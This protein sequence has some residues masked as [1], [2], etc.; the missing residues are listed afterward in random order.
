[1]T[2]FNRRQFLQAGG[3]VLGAAALYACARNPKQTPAPTPDYE[4][5]TA[6]ELLDKPLT[7]LI[8]VFGPDLKESFGRIIAAPDV[9]PNI[10]KLSPETNR[11][12]INPF[13]ERLVFDDG[14]PTSK[15]PRTVVYLEPWVTSYFYSTEVGN[16]SVG[17]TG[18]I[19]K[20]GVNVITTGEPILSGT[21]KD[22]VAMFFAADAL[23][24]VLG[25]SLLR[26]LPQSDQLGEDPSMVFAGFSLAVKNVRPNVDYVSGFLNRSVCNLLAE[27]VRN[28]GD[29]KYE[30]D[31]TRLVPGDAFINKIIQERGISIGDLYGLHKV[32]DIVGFTSRLSG[33]PE[34]ELRQNGLFVISMMADLDRLISLIEEGSNTADESFEEYS[35]KYF[36]KLPET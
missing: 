13:K 35:R 34:E 14:Q 2:E 33:Q 31:E 20:E 12:D 22:A 15:P 30:L 26:Q 1:M 6:G 7:E 8:N 29:Q 23:P 32:S 25:D 18:E 16:V 10:K 5:L 3:L 28:K 11:A 24:L 17:F 27:V 4:Y 9:W 19:I 36:P 21:G